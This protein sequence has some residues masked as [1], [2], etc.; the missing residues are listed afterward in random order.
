MRLVDEIDLQIADV[1]TAAEVILSDK[2]V[3]IDRCRGSGKRL[4][5]GDFG[6]RRQI[7][8]QLMQH[9]GG[10]LQRRA[11]RHVDDHLEFRL[12]VERQHLHDHQLER[13][14][15]EGDDDQCRDAE[16]QPKAV[17][18]AFRLVEERRKD[19][20]E[21]RSQPRSLAPGCVS[22]R[23]VEQDAREPWSNG[24]GDRK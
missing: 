19:A 1:A 11:G 4:V 20:R 18:G 22:A 15:R 9:R 21:R 14:Q 24:E 23:M 12:V 5:V 13:R 7:G 2:S 6:H 16:P 10:A 3:E 17:A 8:A